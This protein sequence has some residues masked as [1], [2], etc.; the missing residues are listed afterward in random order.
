VLT[1]ASGK[2]RVRLQFFGKPLVE[3]R[4]IHA[5]LAELRFAEEEAS[6]EFLADGLEPLPGRVADDAVK[7]RL[8]R[9]SGRKGVLPNSTMILIS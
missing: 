7:A 5:H 6:G 4:A 9:S 2:L 1:P 8:F 3:G